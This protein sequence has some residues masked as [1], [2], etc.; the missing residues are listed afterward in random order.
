MPLYDFKCPD[1]HTFEAL[2]KPEEVRECSCGKPAVAML[3]APAFT[4]KGPGFY[5]KGRGVAS[6]DRA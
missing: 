2:A 1:G 3:G 6:K 5:D 4:F